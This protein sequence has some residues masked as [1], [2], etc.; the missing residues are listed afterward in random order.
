MDNLPNQ[1]I[2]NQPPVETPQK[3]FFQTP[4]GKITA[5]VGTAAIL[6]ITLVILNYFNILSLFQQSTKQPSSN[7]PKDKIF[8]PK[9]LL[10]KILPQILTKQILPKSVALIGI[11][12]DQTVK[13]NF[14]ASWNSSNVGTVSA[15]MT[16]S[17]DKQD[18]SSLYITFLYQKIASVSA[19]LAAK[20]TPEFFS[21]SPKGEWGCQPI[22]EMT[23]CEN[24][25]E[26][27]GAR[28][29][30]SIQY[31]VLVDNK[32]SSVV[33]FCEHGKDSTLYEWRSCT[34]EFAKTG[35]K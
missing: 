10:N 8:D 32:T 17:S 5:L 31:P 13:E 18:V 25:W 27:N 30:I 23:Y 29:G 35:V 2:P 9:V 15:I 19:Q 3:S 26:E 14:I 7:I 16:V 1:P 11:Q 34:S 4:S 24:F 20:I 6:L 22:S 33:S 21:I 12:Q 28:K